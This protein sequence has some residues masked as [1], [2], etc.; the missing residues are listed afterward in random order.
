MTS[1]DRNALSTEAEPKPE[2]CRG[3]ASA[4]CAAQVVEV[5]IEQFILHGF[6][7]AD[8]LRIVA[9]FEGELARLLRE[10]GLP[11]DVTARAQ[12]GTI[13]AGAFVRSPL[14]SPVSIG[15]H[16][17]QTVYGGLSSS[18]PGRPASAHEGVR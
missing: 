12:V 6:S 5:H 9:A 18:G 4:V 8:R 10:R 15:D 2:H 3:A 13:D 16:V 17:A 14:A 11:R 1:R 7:P